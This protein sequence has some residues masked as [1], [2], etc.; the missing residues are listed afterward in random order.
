MFINFKF[1]RSVVN[2]KSFM[3]DAPVIEQLVVYLFY[4]KFQKF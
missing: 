1:I 3:I 2:L 4:N